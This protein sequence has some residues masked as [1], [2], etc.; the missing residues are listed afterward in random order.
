M[1]NAL[2]TEEQ[3]CGCLYYYK[4]KDLEV[5]HRLDGPAGETKHCKQLGTKDT[6]YIDG[7]FYTK[8]EWKEHPIVVEYK[9][10]Q[11][12]KELVNED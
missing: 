3:N 11:L 8:K 5:L 12:I 7:M 2:Y 10:K 6:Y 9:R 4:D 1:K